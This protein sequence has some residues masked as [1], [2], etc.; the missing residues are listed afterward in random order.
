MLSQSSTKSLGVKNWINKNFVELKKNNP[1]TLI[2]VRECSDVD[3]IITA[4]YD[5]GAERKVICEYATQEEVEDIVSN[6]VLESEKINSS[7]R[8][9]KI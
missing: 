6:L 2:L 5:Y 1:D 9:N 8:N 3:P 7:I 4:R